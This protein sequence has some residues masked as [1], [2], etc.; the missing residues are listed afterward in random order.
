MCQ[1]KIKIVNIINNDDWFKIWNR[2]N[3]AGN[4]KRNPANINSVS[5]VHLLI[6]VVTLRGWSAFLTNFFNLF[7]SKMTFLPFFI[8]KINST[9]KKKKV[10]KNGNWQLNEL[11]LCQI[12][13]LKMPLRGRRLASHT[14]PLTTSVVKNVER[15]YPPWFSM[16][17][18]RRFRVISVSDI[19]IN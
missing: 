15:R 19:G 13:A 2:V 1:W 8:L 17:P 11:I 9:S 18:I 14:A 12:L 4:I 5:T 16:K 6:I 10:T 7:S 3:Q